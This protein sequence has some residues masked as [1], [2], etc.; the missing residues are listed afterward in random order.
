[1]DA[2][3]ARDEWL[4]WVFAGARLGDD[5]DDEVDELLFSVPDDVALRYVTEAFEH[6]TELVGGFSD[7]EL[8]AGLW[9]LLHESGLVAPPA[10][11]QEDLLRAIRATTSLYRDLFDPRCTP[12]L[13]HLDEPS[14]PL[15]GPC[16]MWWDIGPFSAGTPAAQL[17]ACFDVLEETLALGNDACRESALHGLGHLCTDGPVELRRQAIL[18]RFLEQDG[19]LRPELV[20]YAEAAR[21][22]CVL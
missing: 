9:F 13:S 15:N 18:A 1:V 19:S 8:C 14:S 5:R 20:R 17:E 21:S 4:G 3:P 12:C 2:Y 11:P 16:Y 10:A 6:S 22:G 7:E